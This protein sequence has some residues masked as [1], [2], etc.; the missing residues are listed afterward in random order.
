MYIRVL[1]LALW[2]GSPLVLFA[3]PP[4]KV[5][6]F[7]G[8]IRSADSPG[9][10]FFRNHLGEP[11]G[12]E[13]QILSY[14]AKS[15]GRELEVVW[16][17]DFFKLLPAVESGL[18]DIAAGT[19]TVTPERSRVADFSKSYFPVRV[20][21]VEPVDRTTNSVSGLAGKRIGSTLGI[22]PDIVLKSETEDL[23]GLEI[24]YADDAGDL[25]GLLRAG[26]IDA[27]VS[28]TAVAFP[29]LQGDAG[30]HM[31]LVL[32]E[33]QHFGFAVR[34]GSSLRAELDSHLSL[35][36][37]SKIYHR[38]LEQFFGRQAASVVK[39]IHGPGN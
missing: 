4:I 39:S 5:A 27:Y 11:D 29:A 23:P 22:N 35:L 15:Q 38:W 34:K 8:E 37:G 13:Y 6:T 1:V 28:E 14:F 32:G 9:H 26:E 31:T 16:M 25:R 18:V 24:V 12:L 33:E 7:G 30:V 19:I 2:V 10:F 20:I 3:Q 21:L 36:R 17:D